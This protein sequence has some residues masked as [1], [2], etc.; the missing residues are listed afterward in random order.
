MTTPDEKNKHTPPA[1]GSEW[2]FQ[3][4]APLAFTVKKVVGK[5]VYVEVNTGLWESFDLDYFILNFTNSADN[6]PKTED[7]WIPVSERLPDDGQMV[8]V[9]TEAERIVDV[10]RTATGWLEHTFS[11]DSNGEYAPGGRWREIEF[12]ITYWRPII[13]PLATKVAKNNSVVD[14]PRGVRITPEQKQKYDALLAKMPALAGMIGLLDGQYSLISAYVALEGV[15]TGD[16]PAFMSLPIGKWIVAIQD[17]MPPDIR[18]SERWR[19]LL[20]LAGETGRGYEK[21]RNAVLMQ[22]MW[23]S[24][25]PNVGGIIERYDMRADWSRMLSRRTY[26]STSPVVL[27]AEK[28]AHSH[29]AG[30]AFVDAVDRVRNAVHFDSRKQDDLIASQVGMVAVSIAEVSDNPDYWS[31]LD[32]CGLLEKLNNTGAERET[33]Q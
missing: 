21:E 19:L 7:R 27:S 8:D 10:K 29:Q 22:W 30:W 5:R 13:N 20:F 24:V 11:P 1:V 15:I 4:S 23:E 33:K 18:D 26:D 32:L 9:F 16:V 25:L 31:D 14:G 6:P 28:C 3:R 2:Y 12:R 17:A